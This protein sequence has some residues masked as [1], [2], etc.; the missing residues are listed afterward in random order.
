MILI[1]NSEDKFLTKILLSL[2]DS[3]L[4]INI[5]TPQAL[6][7]WAFGNVMLVNVK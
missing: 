2:K 1:L 6:D 3:K 4:A 5:Y 7:V